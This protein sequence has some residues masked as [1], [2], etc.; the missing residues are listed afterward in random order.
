MSEERFARQYVLLSPE[1]CDPPHKL[2]L[3]PGSRDSIKVDWLTEAF[4]K[5][6]FSKQHSCLVGYPLNGRVQLLSGTHRHEAAKRAHIRLPVKMV[7]RSLVEA[8]WGT[9]NWADL[10]KDI[11]VEE[12]EL[13]IV[14]DTVPPGID[15]RVNLERYYDGSSS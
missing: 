11:P 7:L 3:S 12:L 14:R 4:T 10:I 15:E 2:D 9:D 1:D 13:A 5:E 6:G 8:Y